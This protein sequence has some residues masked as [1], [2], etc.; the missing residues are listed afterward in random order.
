MNKSYFIHE[1]EQKR[2]RFKTGLRQFARFNW[3]EHEEA[4]NLTK[5]ALARSPDP[6]VR[7][8]KW[9][10]SEKPRRRNRRA[11][12]ILPSR[13]LNVSTI[14]FAC[15]AMFSGYVFAQHNHVPTNST[16][17]L[18]KASSHINAAKRWY[19]LPLFLLIQTNLA[20]SICVETG[21]Y[22]K[23]T[24]EDGQ[25]DE[26]VVAKFPLV[27]HFELMIVSITFH[28]TANTFRN[29]YCY[30]ALKI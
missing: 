25:Y 1:Y 30:Q 13:S 11:K 26:E 12:I 4:F 21:Y 7:K 14:K 27:Q 19:F 22:A 10:I 5:F 15:L 3:N 24:W 17:F 9:S 29:L 6:F 20:G 28:G 23:L 8:V 18:F 2:R 16:F